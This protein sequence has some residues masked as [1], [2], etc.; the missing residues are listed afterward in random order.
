MTTLCDSCNEIQY[1]RTCDICKN[2]FCYGCLKFYSSCACLVNICWNCVEKC[3][4]CGDYESK[5]DIVKCN[6]C[7]DIICN[8]CI[9]ECEECEKLMC[10]KCCIYLE[11]END[12][13]NLCK[14]CIV[15]KLNKI[16]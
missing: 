1:C 2:K 3:S 5:N 10:N 13:Y 8:N 16:Y 15:K 12:D 4:S 11:G 9:R 6:K 14:G 7:Q